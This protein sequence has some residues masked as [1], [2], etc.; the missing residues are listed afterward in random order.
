M[1]A[2][3]IV[4]TRNKT[5]SDASIK[6]GCHGHWAKSRSEKRQANFKIYLMSV[7][8][9]GIF[10]L[11]SHKVCERDYL[12][13]VSFQKIFMKERISAASF[14]LYSKV[15]LGWSVEIG[16]RPVKSQEIL[17]PW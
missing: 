6:Q 15:C 1:S 8:S 7:T 4:T 13:V 10:V 14:R 3:F 17:L 16:L 9:Q 5:T 11:S 2:A 12:L